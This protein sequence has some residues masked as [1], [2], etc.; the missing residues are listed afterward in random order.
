MAMLA[1][2]P[3]DSKDHLQLKL[4][5]RMLSASALNATE[6]CKAYVDVLLQ[7][8]LYA[9]ALAFLVSDRGEKI[10]LLERRVENIRSTLSALGK[11]AAAAAA[12]RFLV[13]LSSDNWKYYVWYMDAFTAS[14]GHL[15]VDVNDAAVAEDIVLATLRFR[16][17][18]R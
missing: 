14:N 2:V 12:A 6:A 1:Q 7:Q 11:T 5:T 17:R 3:A 4:T 8:E 16:G 13:T 10:G 18:R 9:E 15:T